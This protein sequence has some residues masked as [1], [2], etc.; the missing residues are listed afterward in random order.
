MTATQIA[1]GAG[2]RHVRVWQL[3]ANG[4]PS[5]DQSGTLG[6]SGVRLTGVKAFNITP[7]DVTV[8]THKG[9][10]VVFGQDSLPP[11]SLETATL[12]TGK[13]N[14]S[15]DAILG[16]TN[17]VTMGEIVYGAMGTDQQG[18][19]PQVMVY[20]WRQALDFDPASATYGRRQYITTIYPNAVV[21]PKGGQMAEEAVDE[22]EYSVTPTVVKKTPWGVT[23]TTAIH[24]YT[25]SV[26]LRLTSD[27]PLAI[28]RFDGQGA[29]TAE[30]QL[31]FTP[32]SAAKTTVYVNGVEATVSSVDTSGKTFTLSSA[33]AASAVVVAIYETTDLT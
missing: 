16:G 6:Y 28:E 25:Q 17:V 22:N 9:D 1:A 29:G 13:T 31:E 33:P 4:Y 12:T 15:I 2:L 26:R 7:P 23:F 20:G 19:E 8:V 10:D 14:L 21:V 11:G 30:F 27:N 18:S 32:I 24:N 3:D 5:G